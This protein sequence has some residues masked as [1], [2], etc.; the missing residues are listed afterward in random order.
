[1]I[2]KIEIDCDPKHR[3]NEE[4]IDDTIFMAYASVSLKDIVFI[5]NIRIYEFTEEKIKI[6]DRS[7]QHHIRFNC[8]KAVVKVHKLY[9]K[10]AMDIVG[11]FFNNPDKYLPEVLKEFAKIVKNASLESA[12]LM[13]N[14]N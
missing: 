11:E 2:T 14:D 1:M 7:S 9:E 5:E 4:V 8:E 12:E 6:N 10:V 13:C 3:Y